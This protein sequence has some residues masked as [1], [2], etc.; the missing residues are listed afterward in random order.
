[1]VIVISDFL[2]DQGCEKPLQYLADFG[3]ELLLIQV[4][5]EEDRTPPWMGELELAD[6]ESGERIKMQVDEGARER[7]TA[8]FD[9]YAKA[10][11]TAR[12]AKR[13]PVCGRLHLHAASKT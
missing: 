13:R 12:F 9:R 2:D 10:L 3:H 6:A 11:R 4:W 7:Y 1:M 8:A 5:A